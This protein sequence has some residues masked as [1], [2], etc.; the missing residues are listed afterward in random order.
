MASIVDRIVSADAWDRLVGSL[1]DLGASP[2]E[3][4]VVRIVVDILWETEGITL[5]ED[6]A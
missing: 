2:P 4:E 5:D 1:K 3:G 6:N